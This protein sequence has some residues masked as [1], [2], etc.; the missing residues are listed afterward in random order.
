[1]VI[2]MYK[3]SVQFAKQ[4]FPRNSLVFCHI[5]GYG[6]SQRLFLFRS[7]GICFHRY[8]HLTAHLVA[9]TEISYNIQC[10]GED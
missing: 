2:E 7:Y 6:L 1:M 5:F 10:H 8:E 4:I 9:I 3:A